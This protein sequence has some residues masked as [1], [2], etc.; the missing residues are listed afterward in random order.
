ML[1]SFVGVSH[2]VD[3]GQEEPQLPDELQPREHELKIAAL[4]WNLQST[5]GLHRRF[6]FEITLPIRTTVIR[7]RF[8]DESGAE[9]DN[10]ESIH[11]RNETLAGVGDLT[12]GGRVVAVLPDDVD[13]WTLALRGAL[14]LP[15]GNIEADPFVLGEDGQVHQ[16]M[17][18]G[19]GTFDPMVGLDTRY[20]FDKWSLVGWGSMQ[21]R[22]YEN[23]QGY[24]GSSVV[25]G[26]FGAQSAFGLERWAFMLQPEVYFETAARWAG[27]AARN[28][29]RTSLLGTVGVFA[30]PAPQW[31]INALAKI[32]AYTWSQGGQVRWPVVGLLGFTFTFDIDED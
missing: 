5:I 32:P 8:N 19:S 30:F 16:H 12:L 20:A 7:A 29:G 21:L 17:F 3:P 10:V 27:E 14:S 11:H 28:S 25:G 31:Q 26:G 6:G 13:G 2:L 23:S 4:Q 18:F 15:T 22:L 24:R 1:G 9:I